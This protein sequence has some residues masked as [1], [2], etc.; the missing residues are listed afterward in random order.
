[1]P[2]YF[3]FHPLCYAFETPTKTKKMSP[4]SHPFSAAQA[5]SFDELYN[6]PIS[7]SL[8]DLSSSSGI[9]DHSPSTPLGMSLLSPANIS[10]PGSNSAGALTGLGAH[11]TGAYTRF[12]HRYR[13]ME[14]ELRRE[15]QDLEREKQE[16]N[17]LKYVS[18]LLGS[19]S[20]FSPC[21]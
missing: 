6:S 9:P 17:A 15:K 8:D 7:S 13:R 11:E 20:Y 16:H 1:M 21:A 10:L 14:E 2:T 4:S 3:F 12:V 19:L 18:W 5:F